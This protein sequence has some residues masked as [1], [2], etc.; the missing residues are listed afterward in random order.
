MTPHLTRF[1]ANIPGAWQGRA[2]GFISGSPQAHPRVGAAPLHHLMICGPSCGFCR[3]SGPP[4]AGK[5]DTSTDRKLRDPA[6]TTQG[7]TGS[8]PPR[9]P[10]PSLPANTPWCFGGS[11]SWLPRPCKRSLIH[12]ELSLHGGAG[13]VGIGSKAE[14][15]CPIPVTPGPTPL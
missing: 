2:H 13:D 15:M 11:F 9:S 8:S 1:P 3:P 7:S 4:Q 6:G 14:P 10:N 12:E 5:Q